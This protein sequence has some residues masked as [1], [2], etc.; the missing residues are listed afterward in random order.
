MRERF[1]AALTETLRV[2]RQL[3]DAC[4]AETEAAASAIVEALEAGGKV[5]A[6]GNGGSAAQAQHMAGELVG[7]LRLERRALAAVAL[8]ADASILTAWAND[9]GFV[10]VFA[11]Q[12]EALGRPG[13]VL[14]ALSTSGESENVLRAVTRA[15]E[16]GLVTVG[17]SGPGGRLRGMVTHALCVPSSDTQRVQ[18]GH[19]FL[20]HTLCEWVEAALFAEKI[21]AEASEPS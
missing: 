10:D 13:D 7:R 9:C 2:Q 17:L 21:S 12:T 11:R 20:I 16:M 8:T 6:C 15:A 5:L 14:V 19:L 4:L 3:L 1:E 18:E